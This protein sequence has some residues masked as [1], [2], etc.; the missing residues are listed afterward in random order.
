[1]KEFAVLDHGQRQAAANP[2]RRAQPLRVG[3]RGT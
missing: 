1:M 2:A 3:L